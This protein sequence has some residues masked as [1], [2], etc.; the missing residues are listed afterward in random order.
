VPAKRFT[1]ETHENHEKK[2]EL[3]AKHAKR[4]K[5]KWKKGKG[6]IQIRAFSALIRV[7]RG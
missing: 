7:I 1:H 5:G 6:K 2:E 4:S 3:P